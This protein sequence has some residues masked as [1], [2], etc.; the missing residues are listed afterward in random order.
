MQSVKE[1]IE[2]LEKLL[3]GNSHTGVFAAWDS[4]FVTHVLPYLP[5]LMNALKQSLDYI[6]RWEKTEKLFLL[7]EELEKMSNQDRKL[8]RVHVINPHLF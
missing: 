5:V 6:P 2:E 8:M 1:Q 3:K 4:H 7:L